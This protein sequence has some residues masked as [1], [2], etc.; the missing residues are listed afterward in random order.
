MTL[1][2]QTIIIVVFALAM[3]FA[4]T[5]TIAIYNAKW[6]I[7][8]QLQHN[9]VDT[10]TSLGLSVSSKIKD[11]NETTL[12]L[13]LVSAIFDRGF[14]SE[15]SILDNSG[16]EIVSR[17]L[18]KNNI[19]V[20]NWFI[21]IIDI[22]NIKQTALIMQGWRQIGEV[23]V[24]SDCHMAYQALWS[25]AKI[26]FLLFLLVTVPIILFVVALIKIT[27]KP[28]GEITKQ[29]EDIG[30]KNLYT[31]DFFRNSI[32]FGE[33]W[34]E[35]IQKAISG[36]KFNFYAQPVRNGE[37]EFHR[38]CYIKLLS[39]DQEIAAS[40]FFP[41]IEKYYL[42]SS[43]DR[44]VVSEVGN[45]QDACSYTINL[46]NMTVVN[47]DEQNKFINLL[48]DLKSKFDC[49]FSFE[50]SEFTLMENMQNAKS[51]V[52]ACVSLG[53]QVGID[54]VGGSLTHLTHL[55]E[56]NISYLKLDASLTK[57]IEKNQVHQE[58]I[59]KWVNLVANLEIVLIASAVE[60]E[61]QM[62]FLSKLGVSYFQGN[63]IQT[64]Q[65]ICK[66]KM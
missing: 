63:Y 37:Q 25:T 46:S 21:S 42:G 54:R 13:S 6:Y 45:L 39:D 57:N 8:E 52:D 12:M 16:K 64:P 9:A 1:V 23:V 14:Y 22:N 34:K 66:P 41:I 43:I 24:Q 62:S 26:L 49:N 2:K 3:I 10:A 15:I 17:Y 27:F 48:N 28:L 55:T 38:E 11:I 65:L 29:A 32:D 35:R 61:S 18:E 47:I 7:E 33:I 60:I 58:M 56:L 19:N 59:E 40:F 51:L 5:F 53:I 44:L 20:P 36:K 31:I 50:F 30:R 4:S